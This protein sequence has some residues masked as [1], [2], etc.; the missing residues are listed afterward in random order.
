LT[1]PKEQGPKIPL[2]PSAIKR[3]EAAL[4]ELV[5]CERVLST[6]KPETSARVDAE[7]D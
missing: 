1:A 3:L 2:P 5:E 7:E 6:L 4:S